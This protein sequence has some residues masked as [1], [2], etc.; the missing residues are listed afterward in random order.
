MAKPVGLAAFVSNRITTGSRLRTSRFGRKVK[1]K[2]PDARLCRVLAVLLALVAVL[3]PDIGFAHPVD[4]I[5]AAG[6]EHLKAGKYSE[7][8][9][10]F[11]EASHGQ[12]KDGRTFYLQGIA[13]NRLG[14]YREASNALAR[15]VSLG[16]KVPTL[17]FEA[18][19]AA[20][21]AGLYEFA[22]ERLEAYEKARP[23]RT[24]TKELLGLA[25]LGLERFDRAEQYL[26]AAMAGDQAT[27]PNSLYYL[28]ILELNRGNPK[29]ARQNIEELSRVAPDS[30][31][32]RTIGRIL[33]ELTAEAR[34]AK[35]EAAAKQ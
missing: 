32:A 15:A 21:H 23:D 10:K 13:L 8:L 35:A 7:A 11:H 16:V 5:I 20:A 17:D 27:Q 6:F 2:Y 34:K 12:P 3:R 33:E 29:A 18:G 19:W 22:I 31:Q 25:Y 4:E 14:R 30:R 9:E 26:R 24:K 1:F 28:A